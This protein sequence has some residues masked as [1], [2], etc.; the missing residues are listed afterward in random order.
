MQITIT[1]VAIMAA[2]QLEPR[3]IM[4]LTARVAKVSRPLVSSTSPSRSSKSFV[5]R[6]S[7]SFTAIETCLALSAAEDK[8][9][10]AS[11][12]SVIVAK[13]QGNVTSISMSTHTRLKTFI[14]SNIS[15]CSCKIDSGSG[16]GNDPELSA[17]VP[18]VSSAP[19]SSDFLSS[20]V[21]TLN[22]F[23]MV[24]IRISSES[25]VSFRRSYSVVSLFGTTVRV[26]SLSLSLRRESRIT[27]RSPRVA[28]S[29]LYC[30]ARVVTALQ[31]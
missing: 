4:R 23:T 5:W 30:V 3:R 15:R 28:S 16:E 25:K 8:S 2:R 22:L 13:A 14:P 19:S 6:S 17:R 1:R 20:F 10:K 31:V 18:L 11:S 7:S 12:C 29:T 24:A 27:T 9:S 21:L 26:V